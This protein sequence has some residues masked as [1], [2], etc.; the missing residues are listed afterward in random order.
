M[1]TMLWALMKEWFFILMLFKKGKKNHYLL[2]AICTGPTRI[3]D[4]KRELDSPGP[5]PQIN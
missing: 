3:L 5:H 2:F 4:F 1:P